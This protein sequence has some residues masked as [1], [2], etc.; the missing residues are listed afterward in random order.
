[1]IFEALDS[2]V[3]QEPSDLAQKYITEIQAY[4]RENKAYEQARRLFCREETKQVDTGT[5]YTVDFRKNAL[6]RKLITAIDVFGDVAY[7]KRADG[8]YIRRYEPGGEYRTLDGK[9]R[10]SIVTGTSVLVPNEKELQRIQSYVNT[11]DRRGL[12][13]EI[14]TSLGEKRV[15]ETS[16]LGSN[17][18]KREITTYFRESTL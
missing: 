15:F 3:L 13:A 7:L 10:L 2:D 11:I 6:L 9:Q 1:M 14:D 12:P 5:I 4:I 16:K 17:G 18:E 8:T